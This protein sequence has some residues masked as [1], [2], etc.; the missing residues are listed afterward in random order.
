MYIQRAKYWLA[1]GLRMTDATA[2][3]FGLAGITP[4]SPETVIK[5]E[6]LKERAQ[7]E[8]KALH[9]YK[10]MKRKEAKET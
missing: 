7:L 9:F 8:A 10:D 4:L 2:I 3:I 6:K 1:C 5:T